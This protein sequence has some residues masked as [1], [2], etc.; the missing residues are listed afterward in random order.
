MIL[1]ERWFLDE[2]KFPVQFGTW[3]SPNSLVPVAVALGITIIATLIYGA[4][5]ADKASC[6][7]RSRSGCRGRIT[8]SS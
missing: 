7:A 4:L 1:H 3:S 8:S 2:T 6:P 5:A